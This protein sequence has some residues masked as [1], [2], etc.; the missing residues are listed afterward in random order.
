ME[1]LQWIGLSE[2]K[3]AETLKNSALTSLLEKIVAIAKEQN[4]QECEKQKV[5]F[6]LIFPKCRFLSSGDFL[7]S[8]SY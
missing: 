4:V 5:F 7:L 2:A 8:N 3:I 1:N 6:F